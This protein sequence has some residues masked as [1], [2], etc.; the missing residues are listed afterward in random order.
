MYERVLGPDHDWTVMARADMGALRILQGREEEGRALLGGFE[1]RIREWSNFGVPG[2]VELGA[3]Q[4]IE[5]MIRLLEEVGLSQEA[6][7]FQAF[8]LDDSG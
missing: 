4:S 1:E 6:A 2:Q 3:I 7:V 8:L 5:S